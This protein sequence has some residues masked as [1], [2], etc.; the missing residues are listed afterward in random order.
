MATF[1]YRATDSS[2]KTVEGTMDAQDAGAV[3][4]R[5]RGLQYY[6][7]GIRKA[8]SETEK[9]GLR[10]WPAFLNRGKI[11]VH[12][13]QQLAVLVGAGLPLDRCLFISSELVE[14]RQ[15]QGV[16]TR[17][18][19]SV[20][21][22]AS[23]AEALSR[24]PRWFSDLYVSMVSAGEASGALEGILEQLAEFLEEWQRFRD[25]IVTALVYPIFLFFFAASAV[26]VLL[27]F[28]VPKFATVFADMGQAMPGPARFLVSFSGGLRAYWWLL[29]AGLIMAGTAA[30]FFLRSSRGKEWIDRK[31]LVMPL[32]GDLVVKIQVSRFARVLGTLVTGG[33]PILKALE[34]V[35]GTLT[36]TVFSR[37]VTRA[38]SGLKEGQ[39]VA[40]PLRR[41]GVFP[42]LFLHMVTVGEETGKLEEMLLTTART[43]D[44][45]VERGAKRL[46]SVFEP[47]IILVMG[48]FIGSII[49]SI[50]WA[51]FSINQ[52][53]F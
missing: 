13:T 4:S 34:I 1:T 46:L 52:V 27:L 51:I 22:G 9:T 23:L 38:Q 28:V 45:E 17:A 25:T 53:V 36:N 6:P 12:F 43:Y 16:I 5:L 7:L 11:L 29:A 48:I 18:R 19:R 42:A 50:L 41:S 37:S 47:V 3:A 26:V 21:E 15:F 39:G 31:V 8:D 10:L 33:V 20:E 49:L 2:G 30:A 44:R 40:E 32:L 24:H 14:D 35:T